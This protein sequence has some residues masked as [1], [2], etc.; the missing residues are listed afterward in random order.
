MTDKGIPPDTKG[1]L[2]EQS[3]GKCAICGSSSYLEMA[4]ITPFVE[5]GK[6]TAENLILLCPTCNA[7]VDSAQFPS[8][9]LAEIKE[10]W[11][12]K[13]I[14]GKEA[15]SKIATSESQV[16]TQSDLKAWAGALE[17]SDQFDESV[18]K[19]VGELDSIK[20]EDR[21]I[22]DVLRPLIT[23]LRFEGVTILHHTGRPEHG[24]DLVFHERD[25]VGGFTF[26]AIVACVGKIHARSSAASDSGH[27]QKLQDQ[28][29][30]CFAIP[31]ED[32]NLKASFHI[33][34][35]IVACNQVI[36]DE[37]KRMFR[38]WE[39]R[40]R[41]RLIFWDAADIAGHKLRMLL[42]QRHEAR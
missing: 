1:Q 2:L 3:R 15:V 42:G 25:R 37:A 10:A 24:K 20:S 11:E 21:F 8:E 29:C 31:F 18:K 6:S 14:P 22:E 19:I 5:G 28:V 26:Y 40:E 23:A 4:H 39:D 32:H 36:T 33:D 34:K 27:Y 41:R 38:A 9:R 30:K 17:S 16:S 7:A 13:R 35:V 12:Q